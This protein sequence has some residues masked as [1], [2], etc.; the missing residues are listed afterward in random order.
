M[1]S[2][3]F[4]EGLHSDS[5]NVCQWLSDHHISVSDGSDQDTRI[6]VTYNSNCQ[7]SASTTLI[8]NCMTTY[9]NFDCFTL[10]SPGE[11][12]LSWTFADKPCPPNCG[13]DSWADDADVIQFIKLVVFKVDISQPSSWPFPL[14]SLNSQTC[15]AT[16][17]PSAAL[18]GAFS[19]SQDS[20]DGSGSFSPN[21]TSSSTTVFTAGLNGYVYT[22]VSYT[23]GG[24]SASSD[25]KTFIVFTMSIA[26][27]SFV[28]DNPMYF[29]GDHD[30]CGHPAQPI[31]YVTTKIIS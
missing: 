1:D 20:G 17:T 23:I 27:V 11:Y 13:P 3:T 19:W 28:E 21:N 10:N 31:R 15:V 5:Y 8:D 16:V 29:D 12:T 7:T 6:I 4:Y 9:R 26:G 30:G 22:H 25:E 2:Q 24:A 18:G 14:V